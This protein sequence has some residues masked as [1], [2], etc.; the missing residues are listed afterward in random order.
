MRDSGGTE[1]SVATTDLVNDHRSEQWPRLVGQGASDGV[2][3]I[4]W[5]K[6]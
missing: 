3:R 4:T 1:R 2:E 6:G 5:G